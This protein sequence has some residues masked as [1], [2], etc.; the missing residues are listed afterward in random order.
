MIYYARGCFQMLY[1]Y[2]ESAISITAALAF[3][4]SGFGD[5]VSNQTPVNTSLSVNTIAYSA[6]VSEKY[7]N[8]SA[9]SEIN[10]SR[11]NKSLPIQ[12]SDNAK[13]I[14]REQGFDA[15][16]SQICYMLGEYFSGCRVVADTFHDFDANDD[17]LTLYVVDEDEIDNL[18]SK[19]SRFEDMW[20]LSSD[21]Y[22]SG[23]ILIDV[24]AL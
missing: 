20:W 11:I 9:D 1:N 5:Y 18:M 21:A 2:I 7:E 15:Y 16:V 17:I 8:T 23:K 10:T 22:N 12:F 14:I 19:L 13:N 3:T 6:N 24:M 4:A